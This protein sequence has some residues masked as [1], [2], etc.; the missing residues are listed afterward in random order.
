MTDNLNQVWP[1]LTWSLLA[2]FRNRWPH[3]VLCVESRYAAGRAEA[4]H[5]RSFP[6]AAPDRAASRRG[7]IAATHHHC[8]LQ[9]VATNMKIEEPS[10][11]AVEEGQELQQMS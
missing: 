4:G 2:S 5:G 3:A 1:W 11:H 7:W 8:H 6:G 9:G 10:Q